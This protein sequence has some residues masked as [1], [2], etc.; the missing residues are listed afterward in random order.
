MVE[1]PLILL[2]NDD[3][4]GS[5]GLRSAAAALEDLGELLIVAPLVQRSGMGR[6]WP[7]D[8]T[9]AITLHE[10]QVA[11]R[12][13]QAYA[14]DGS[15]AQVV[16]RALLLL[17]PRR[18]ALTVSG[19]NYGQNPG[20]TVTS[21]GTVGA[22]ME[23][24]L[25]GI[26]GIA[27]SLETD[28]AYF[29][30]QSEAVDFSAAAHFTRLFASRLLALPGLPADV[31]LIKVEVPADATPETTWQVASQSRRRYFVAI[32]PERAGLMLDEPVQ[33]DFRLDPSGSEPGSDVHT[34][35]IGRRVAVTP[36]SIDL[37]SRVDLAE[38]GILFSDG[39]DPA[40][41]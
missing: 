37:T 40:S 4:Y 38:L 3:G 17:A 27:V 18:P 29:H 9:G 31:D 1:R 22:A 24:A 39:V 7:R 14:I 6:A 25:S 19:I 16:A 15:P 21:S 30:S 41:A 5:P 13:R 8:A 2:T 34:L 12:A 36:L 32:P 35:A 11:G 20:V 23:A 33:I 28:R 26:P 10:I